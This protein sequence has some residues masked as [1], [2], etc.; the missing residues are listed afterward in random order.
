MKTN[1][2][3]RYFHFGVLGLIPIFSA[4]ADVSVNNSPVDSDSN[5]DSGTD[6][7]VD[8]DSDADSDS[9]TDSDSD[10]DSDTDSDA[11]SDSDVDCS[12]DVS[13]TFDGGTLPE[14]WSIET[15]DD[16]SYSYAWEWSNASNTTGG[17]G[18]Y[19]WIDGAYPVE[20]DD[21]FISAVYT[22]GDCSNIV[23]TFNQDFVKSGSD[24][25]GFVQL[26][27]DGGTW[28]TLTTLLGNTTGSAEV[29]LSS[30][31][32]SSA[33]G[34]QIRFRYMGNDDQSWKVDDF[35]IAGTP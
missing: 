3:L 2:F 4:C 25:F 8:T 22:P 28:Q 11:D 26:K 29:D 32:T 19:W 23:L 12:L 18:G 7:D 16:D 35:E 21:S 14:G 20:F 17:T 13:E 27:I 24:D 9:D 10:S 15:F 31:L 6:S 34:F 1:L 5:L 30:Y 33:T